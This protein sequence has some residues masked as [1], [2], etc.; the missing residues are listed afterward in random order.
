MTLIQ[1]PTNISTGTTLS[2][3]QIFD[4]YNKLSSIDASDIVLDACSATTV[5]S[6]NESITLTIDQLQLV[7]LC[8]LNK[9]NI[10]R[11][12]SE[13]IYTTVDQIVSTDPYWDF[14]TLSAEANIFLVNYISAG[15]PAK[16][17]QKL[18][19]KHK[20]T[21]KRNWNFICEPE[22]FVVNPGNYN[23]LA[24]FVW[25]PHGDYP[26]FLTS[27]GSITSSV[28]ALDSTEISYA[29]DALNIYDQ[30]WY[31]DYN[32]EINTLTANTL[33]IDK[34]LD[35]NVKVS[36][37]EYTVVTGMN[38]YSYGLDVNLILKDNEYDP[39]DNIYKTMFVTG[40]YNNAFSYTY[41]YSTKVISLLSN[42]DAK[43]AWYSIG[44]I[45]TWS[46]KET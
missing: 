2:A 27:S 9:F 46:I 38:S 26:T 41:Y 25:A 42:A 29:A 18:V 4:I 12:P 10:P 28:S 32:I 24:H 1:A 17:Y 3:S 23:Y 14:S 8:G 40:K 45:K 31:G 19:F 39:G 5:S 13:P 20:Y 33:F 36:Q 22:G 34:C 43:F 37:I 30:L 7:P 11:R 15:T 6:S 21:D 35:K 16:Y 44:D